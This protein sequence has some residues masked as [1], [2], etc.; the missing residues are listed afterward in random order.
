MATKTSGAI[1]FA[2]LQQ[3]LVSQFKDLDPKDPSVWPFVP[4][5]A[6]FAVVAIAV[7]VGLWFAWLSGSDELLRLEQ[8]KKPSCVSTIKP[9]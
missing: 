4:R 2:D 5:Y 6:L 3:R 1:N 8:E 7:V 9:S